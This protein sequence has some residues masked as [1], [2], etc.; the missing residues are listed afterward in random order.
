MDLILIISNIFTFKNVLNIH[1]IL[2]FNFFL[3]GVY[4]LL[5]EVHFTTIFTLKFRNLTKI[6]TSYHCY[7]TCQCLK[8]SHQ[9]FFQCLFFYFRLYGRQQI[10]IALSQNIIVIIYIDSLFRVVVTI[11]LLVFYPFLRYWTLNLKGY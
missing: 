1:E 7:C 6:I 2:Y 5:I 10:T 3:N 9:R 4:K 11:T 8:F